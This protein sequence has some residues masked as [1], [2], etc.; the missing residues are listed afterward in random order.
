MEQLQLFMAGGSGHP[1]RM[2]EEL[3]GGC[4]YW[5]RWEEQ[6]GEKDGSMPNLTECTSKH[7]FVLALLVL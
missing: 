6:R 4:G 7:K 2:E 5:R 1:W 3:V